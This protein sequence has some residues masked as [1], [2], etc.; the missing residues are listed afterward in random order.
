[1]ESSQFSVL[2]SQGKFLPHF[3]V[4]P[5]QEMMVHLRVIHRYFAIFQ[6]H[7]MSVLVA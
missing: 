5:V 1:M 3:R 7:L 4:N 2:A 6:C